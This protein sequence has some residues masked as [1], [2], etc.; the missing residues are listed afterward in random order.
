MQIFYAPFRALEEQFTDYACAL[1]PGPQRQVLVLCPSMRVAA[2]LRRLCAQRA[3]FISHLSFC[4]FSQLL[5]RIDVENASGKAP[6][7]PGDALHDY[8]LKT[9]LSAPPLA[10]YKPSRGL[11]SALRAS[12]RDLADSL[13]EPD[14]LEEQL[15]QT[16]DPQ[17]QPQLAHLQWLVRL[18]GAYLQKMDEI[19][20]YRSYKQYFADALS[21]LP[22]SAYLHSFHEIIVYGFYE[23]T[24]RQLELFGALGDSYPVTAFWLYAKHP[25]FRFGRKFFETNIQGAGP[26]RELAVSWQETA[27]GETLKNLFSPQQSAQPPQ[28][29]HWASAP[30][31][32]GEVFWVVKEMLRLHEEQGVPYEEMAVCARSLQPYKT[33]LPAVCAQNR[34]PL[35]GAFSFSFASQPLGAF[36]LNLLSLR[37]GGFE[38]EDL[39]AVVSSPYFKQKNNW[40]YLI[41]ECLAQRDFSQW[42]DL[43]RPSLSFYDPGFLPWLEQIK[44]RLEFL[45]KPLPWEQLLRAAQ[46]LLAEYVLEEGLTPSEQ[47]L[48]Q[49]TQQVLNG[50]SRYSCISQKAKVGEFLD[51]LFA[52]LQNVSLQTAPASAKGVCA[53]E[54]LSMRGLGFKVVF[55]LGMNEKSFPQIQRQ[56]PFLPDYYR[57]ILRDQLGFWLNQKMER[58]EEERQLFFCLLE[59]AQKQLYVSFLRNDA[60]GKA[61]VPSG[62][63][64]ELARA[65]GT[66]LQQMP[67]THISGRL[68]ERLKQ[69]PVRWLTEKEMS[70][71]LAA[72]GAESQEYAQ[73]SLAGPGEEASLQAARQIACWG[74]LTGRDGAVSCGEEIFL[75]KSQAGLSPSAL[76]DLARCPMKYF[77]SRVVGLTEKEEALSRSELAPDLRGRVYHEILMEYY[78]ALYKEGLAGE[79][80]PSALQQRMEQAIA[81]NYNPQS[82]KRF[83]IY[84][85]IWELLL[86]DI[87]QTLTDFALQDAQ[88]LDGFV[89]SIFETVFEKIYQPS[90]QIKL[91][92]KGIVDRIDVRTGDSCFRVLDY[93]SSRHGS[94]DLAA[95]MFKKVILQP[96]LYLVMTQQQPQTAGLKPA[97]AALLT[98]QKGYS[99]QELSADGFEA[100][101]PRAEQFIALLAGLIRKGVF[102]ISPGL[103]CSYCP[104]AAVCR[105]DAYRSLL[106][107]KHTPQARMLEEAKQ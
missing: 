100:V 29:V 59:S 106:R 34:V 61:L 6:L 97:G 51:E 67:L 107:A 22:Q 87:Q 77:L 90:A 52:A 1:R 98:I 38:H 73:A 30:D 105:K 58:L 25:A 65:A 10:R 75:Q 49:Q 32:Q 20:G 55:L 9:L 93:K 94:K 40:R 102:F 86:Q 82:Y 48:W 3:G 104:Y 85:V 17:L 4:T 80:F 57:R 62:Y 70:V 13:A 50:F 36:L 66:D 14:V 95:D 43:V 47:T 89:P 101:R 18:Y 27:A 83:G 79:L 28:G 88:H 2:R 31:P 68:I 15:Q 76:Q 35:E 84:P 96:F 74:G 5:A 19:P 92:L 54:A 69:T 46:E 12:L 103:H 26:A 53:A 41:K 24:G 56:D 16:S 8:L 78:A 37:R 64:V 72:E 45:D 71:L 63:V 39:L 91:K 99:R 33:L 42:T 44:L 21:A 23:L 81:K 60:E 11:I 7:L